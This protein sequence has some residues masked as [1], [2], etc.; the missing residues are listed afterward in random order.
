MK[1]VLMV[2]ISL[3]VLIA[4]LVVP[5]CGTPAD[6]YNL[7][8]AVSPAASGTTTPTGTTSVAAAA[9]VDITATPAEGWEFV[10]WTAPAGTFLDADAASTKFTMPAEAVTVTANFVEGCEGDLA[11]SDGIIRVGVAGELGH[12]T[13]QFQM[14]GATMAK[15]AIDTMGG[16]VIDGE[17][18]TFVLV[19]IETGEATVDPTGAAGYSAMLAKIDD[20]DFIVGGFRTEAVT[21]YREVAMDAGVIFL[22]CG[23]VSEELQHSVVDDYDG[24][25]YWF[26]YM[27]PNEYGLADAVVRLVDA[28]GRQIRDGLAEEPDYE[29]RAA[30]IHDDLAWAEELVPVIEDLLPGINVDLVTPPVAVDPLLVTADWIPILGAIAAFDPHFIIPLLS[31]DG[32]VAFAGYR[33]AV[34]L[35]A[36]VVGINVPGQFKFPWSAD[37][38]TEPPG[39]PTIRFDVLLDTTAEEVEITALT[40]PFFTAFVGF[41]GDYPLYTAATYDALFGLKAAIE[42]TACYSEDDEKAYTN[43][44]AVIAYFEDLANARTTTAGTTT[45]Y[46]MPGTTSGGKPAL[47]EDQVMALYPH[48]GTAGYPSY[49]AG[50]WTMPSHTTHGLVYGPDYITGIGV[51]WQWDAVALVWKKYAVWPMEIGGAD[52]KDQYGDWNFEYVGTKPMYVF[53]GAIKP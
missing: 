22:A 28:V 41:A 9:E 36:M 6:E 15:G 48:I 26:K 3:L 18:H 40:Q 52:L 53:P 19:P 4:L 29:L 30:I 38:G 21:V 2:P 24:Y 10:N 37:L 33:K 42:A 17:V 25:K 47:T 14:L 51:Q 8:M 13:G 16:V 1:R 5:S 20:V 11:F 32:G 12:M 7:T 45:V 34:I 50:D 44:D 49:A 39:G 27:P 43:T 46:P 23:V 31:A 35:N